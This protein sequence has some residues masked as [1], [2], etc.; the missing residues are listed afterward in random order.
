[1][2]IFGL[3][4]TT[5]LDYPEHL[6]AT[7]FTGGCNFRCPYCHNGELVM[8]CNA[9][10]AISE[11]EVFEHLRRRRNVLEGVCISGG[12]P[13]LQPD[14]KEFIVKIKEL[15]LLVKLDT[16]GTNPTLIRELVEESLL[17]YVAMDIKNVWSKYE[18]TIGS[19]CDISNVIESYELLL[20]GSIEYEFRTTVT[21]ELVTLDD[22]LSVAEI[23]KGARRWYIQN[24]K[25]SD[26]V[27]KKG[28]H[29]YREE[30]LKEIIKKM[31]TSNVYL[32]GID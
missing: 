10:L 23:V 13:T 29:G 22:I 18:T 31:D 11:D 1:M 2:L 24:Y 30:E 20:N 16:N 14:L 28:L 6:A 15:G 8:G 21:K 4:K 19:S 32:R 26:N 17:D 25:E 3:A 5:L 7:I 27:I 9:G 12:E